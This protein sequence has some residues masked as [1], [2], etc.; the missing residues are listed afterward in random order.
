[1]AAALDA[2]IAQLLHPGGAVRRSGI[3]QRDKA[4]GLLRLAHGS[5]RRRVARFVRSRAPD[6]A[7]AHPRARS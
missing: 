4:A 7:G 3:G 2:A 1:M 6:D 5:A